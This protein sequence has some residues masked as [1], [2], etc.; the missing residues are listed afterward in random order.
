MVLTVKRARKVPR[1][2]TLKEVSLAGKKRAHK[3]TIMNKRTY[4]KKK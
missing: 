2:K 4:G 3:G 1:A